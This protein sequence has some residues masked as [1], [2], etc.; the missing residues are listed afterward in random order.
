MERFKTVE[1]IISSGFLSQYAKEKAVPKTDRVLKSTRVEQMIIDDLCSGSEILGE[2]RACGSRKLSTFESLINDVYQSV[3]ALN[4][5]YVNEEN[6]SETSLRFNKEILCDLMSDEDYGAIKRVC[7]G[8]ELP[9]LGATEEFVSGILENLDTLMRKATGGKGNLDALSRIQSDRDGL[10]DTLRELI[11]QHKEQPEVICE[12]TQ[13]KIVN[14]A[15]RAV[16]KQEQYEMYSKLI[17]SNMQ[18][19]RGEIREIVSG[20]ASAALE[21]AND[22]HSI[23][24]SWGDRESEMRKNPVDRDVLKRVAGSYKLRYIAKFLGRYKELLVSKRVASYTYGR[25]EKYDIERGNNI[26]R[27][28]SSE[29]S[30][31]AKW[32]LIPLFLRKYRNKALKQYRKRDPEYKGKGDIIVCLDESQSTFGE[33]N[34]YGM[35]IAMVLY[36]LCKINGTNFALVHFSTRTKVDVFPKGEYIT[37]EEVMNCAETFLGGG[38]DFDEPLREACTLME[39]ERFENPDIVFITDGVCDVSSHMLKTFSELKEGTGAKLTGILLDA[40]EHFSFAL[41]KFADT[42]YRTSELLADTIVERIIEERL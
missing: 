33:N 10:M 34:A 11:E 26:S 42:I 1:E 18:K 12:A 2:H 31:L 6:M 17:E 14:T 35:A 7:E 22:M 36:E 24:L 3:Y 29:M 38:T 23:L 30:L 41:E 13:R 32:E 28:L 8:K 39:D 16:A 4:A 40:G 21:R 27:I 37:V 25:G 19:K 20:A 15:N 5:R 9:A